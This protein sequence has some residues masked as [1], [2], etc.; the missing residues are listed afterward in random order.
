MD[1]DSIMQRMLD[2]VPSSFDRRE[3]SVIWDALSPTAFEMATLYA[4]INTLLNNT[5]AGTADRNWLIK[6][7]AEIGIAPLEATYAYRKM[8]TTPTDLE[9][10]IGERFNFEDL[11]FMVTEKIADGEYIIRCETVGEIGNHGEGNLIPIEYIQGLKTA[12]LTPEVMIYGEEEEDTEV[13]RQRY[14]DTLPTMTLDG[15][16][17]QYKKWCREFAGIGNHEIYPLWNGKNTV[18]VSILSSEN[19][20]ASQELIDSFQE[21][22]DPSTSTINDDR[23]DVNYP[24]GRGLGNGK[25]PIGAVVTVTTAT[26]KPIEVDAVV[27][28][29]SG[30]SAPV[31]LESKI[32]EYL[33]GL[34][35]KKDIVSYVAIS[36]FFQT[37]DAIELV[38]DLNV[39][40]GK[41]NVPIGEEEIVDLT[42]F[43]ITEG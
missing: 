42:S 41:N 32:R 23:E 24:Q 10:P 26:L 22:L 36:A 5:F 38:V 35:Y 33:L 43:T 13:L 37:D 1:F 40:G 16:I 15:N 31:D 29:R 19:T 12:T 2:R 34:N 30:Y 3:G 8:L 25:A 18:K 7:C 39:N 17:A 21:F 9:I 11:N 20:A 28:Y 4:V 27:V 14:F 6:R